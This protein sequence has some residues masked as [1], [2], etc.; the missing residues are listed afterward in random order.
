MEINTIS[1]DPIDNRCII[2]T[3]FSEYPIASSQEMYNDVDN[4][5]DSDKSARVETERRIKYIKFKLFNYI[6]RLDIH[7]KL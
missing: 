3:D 7:K 5:L 4:M 6:F 2:N 1:I